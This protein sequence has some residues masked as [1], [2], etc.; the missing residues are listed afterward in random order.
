MLLV[1]VAEPAQAHSA[2][3]RSEPQDGAQLKQSPNEIKIWFTEPIRVSLSTFEM[4]DES[5]KKLDLHTAQ[6]DEKDAT[7][8]HLSLAEQLRPGL[9]RVTWTAVAQ[10]L[11]PGKGTL[12]FRVRP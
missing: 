6:T 12:S 7:I 3:V 1:A 10:D 5:G 8:V 9:Y 2:F 11:H 4:R